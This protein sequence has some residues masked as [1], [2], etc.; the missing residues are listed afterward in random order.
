LANNLTYS[1]IYSLADA[2]FVAGTTHKFKFT[3]KDQTGSGI[4]I[5]SASCTWR[6]SEY[7]SDYAILTK[8]GNIVATDSFDI[9]LNNTD[10]VGLSGKFTH[11]PYVYFSTGVG[12][13]PAQ[14][15]IVITK[16]IT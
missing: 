9:I 4:N 11:Q 16:G 13:I 15:V 12:V 2:T 10:T 8:V 14:G 5:T 6:M 7:G 1:Q 3:V